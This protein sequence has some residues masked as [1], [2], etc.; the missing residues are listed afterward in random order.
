M[1]DAGLDGALAIAGRADL[2]EAVVTERALAP[3]AAARRIVG[4]GEDGREVLVERQSVE[5]GRRQGPHVLAGLAGRELRA[6]HAIALHEVR[7]AAESA[8]GIAGLGV[9][10]ERA[11]EGQQRV[12]ALVDDG[13]VERPERR[14]ERGPAKADEQLGD[15][16][17]ADGEVHAGQ[18]APQL[19]AEREGGLQ[20]PGEAERQ[21]DG[22]DAR[23]AQ[24]RREHVHDVG[25]ERVA[26][27]RGVARDLLGRREART[28]SGSP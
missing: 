22:A 10:V 25:V 5:V 13:R 7:D 3:V 26:L 16:G 28:A 19:E 21:P 4:Q 15:G 12:L 17:P 1:L 8:R 6:Q 27:G 2:G 20:L 14:R 18:L 24:S 9:L 23:G 11:T